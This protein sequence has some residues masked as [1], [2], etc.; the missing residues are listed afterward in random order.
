MTL[1]DYLNRAKINQAEFARRIGVT[2]FAVS[3]YLAGKRAPRPD[4]AKRIMEV[5]KG[6]VTARELMF[7]RT[8]PGR[9]KKA[10]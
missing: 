7:N 3:L 10:A 4:V 8:V 6:R 1:S 2:R 9:G 5:S